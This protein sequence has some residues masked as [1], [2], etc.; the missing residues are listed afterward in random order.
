MPGSVP[1]PRA[2]PMQCVKEELGESS[3]E[4]D[5]FEAQGSSPNH[6]HLSSDLTGRFFFF[7]SPEGGTEITVENNQ[8]KLVRI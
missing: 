3:R 8:G 1:G 6:L 5:T 7:I 4:E 2:T